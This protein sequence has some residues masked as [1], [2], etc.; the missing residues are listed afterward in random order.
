M[1]FESKALT[2]LPFPGRFPLVGELSLYDVVGTAGVAADLSH[3]DTA[4]KVCTLPFYQHH[5]SPPYLSSALPAN[6]AD[7]VSSV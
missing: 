5:P 4:A 7:N 2:L 1:N 6:T 3:M